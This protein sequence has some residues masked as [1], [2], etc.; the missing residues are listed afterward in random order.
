MSTS[1]VEM[2]MS[3]GEHNILIVGY[4][5]LYVLNVLGFMYDSCKE[6]KECNN[7]QCCAKRHKIGFCMPTKQLGD[8]CSPTF[9]YGSLK[10]GCKKGLTCALV[11]KNKLL[12]LQT[13]RCVE[14]EEEAVAKDVHGGRK[15][16]SKVVR[17]KTIKITAKHL[18]K[19]LD[20]VK[21]T[22]TR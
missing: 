9:L 16:H 13:H 5:L 14:I 4:I 21:Q 17:N 12:H 19:L 20:T 6:Q 11:K 22:D 8:L 7:D 3:M 1:D 18:N 2:K 10:C 15:H